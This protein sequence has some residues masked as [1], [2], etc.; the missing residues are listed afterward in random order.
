MNPLENILEE[1]NY[2]KERVQL[3]EGQL[4]KG[5]Y[6]IDCYNRNKSILTYYENLLDNYIKGITGAPLE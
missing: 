5:Q 6:Y 3:F 4:N 1:I 2:Y